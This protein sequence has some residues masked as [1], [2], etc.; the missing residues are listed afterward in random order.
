MP[1]TSESWSIN[2]KSPV[3]PKTS[4]S[5]SSEITNKNLFQT[6]I[7][8]TEE[9]KKKLKD[10]V[11]TIVEEKLLKDEKLAKDVLH[12]QKIYGE[13]AFIS[14]L[15]D[16]IVDIAGFS[17]KKDPTDKNALEANCKIWCGIMMD[18]MNYENQENTAALSEEDKDQIIQHEVKMI[19]REKFLKNKNYK[20]FREMTKEKYGEESAFN[21]LV[22]YVVDNIKDV[23]NA[24]EFNNKGSYTADENIVLEFC[25]LYCISLQDYEAKRI[26]KENGKKIK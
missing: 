8:T 6:M 21:K 5:T 10:R 19:V 13:V 22:D 23:D 4:S 17:V 16:L 2:S 11:R 1:K 24:G 25:K 26:E 12:L 15:T 7:G 14:K 3:T 18:K 9:E 20:K